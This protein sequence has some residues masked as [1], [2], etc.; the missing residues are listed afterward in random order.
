MK[1]HFRLPLLAAIS[2]LA[3]TA[4]SRGE[5]VFLTNNTPS[6]TLASNEGDA[7]ALEGDGAGTTTALT[8]SADDGGG[9]LNIT[10]TAVTPNPPSL[11]ELGMDAN[12]MGI[13]NE[14]WG[15]NQSWTFKFDRTLSFDGIQLSDAAQ[16][17]DKMSI[18]S[19]AWGSD[20]VTNGNNWSFSTSETAP[21]SGIFIGTITTD[22][23]PGTST[24]YDFTG[25]GLSNIPQDTEI[26]I[27][28]VQGNGAVEMESFTVSLIAES[29]DPS[30]EIAG[31]SPG[32][33]ELTLAGAPD[34]RYE[35]RS[36][37]DL[38]FT[39]GALVEGLVQGNPGTD[40]GVISG[41]NDEF[42]TTDGNGDAVVRVTTLTGP[43]NFVRAQDTGPISLAV[44]DFEADG[45][46]FIPTGDW[47]WGVAASDNGLVDGQVT[48]GNGSDTGKCWATVLGDGG[49]AINGG[50]TPTTDS[51][52]TSPDIDLTGVTG[53]RLEFAAAVDAQTGDTLEVLVRDAGDD[54]LL[55]TITPFA[56]FPTNAA[57][58]ILDF[59]LPATADGNTIYLEFRFQ[60]MNSEFL[61]FYLDDVTITY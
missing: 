27:A 28:W 57:W 37:P 22:I 12:S 41:P 16:I 58:A 33:W 32:V 3:L 29:A 6:K 47:A 40:P 54:S 51:I 34:T 7:A 25:S 11:P 53:A 13:S 52:L 8:L 55:D 46:G 61:G 45:Q 4:A 14:R 21:G 60:G 18:S 20:T 24:I 38:D 44:F 48:G 35:F 5:T 30:L 23:I 56:S 39:P 42:V 15:V 31:V 9:T 49:P 36:S 59:A 50:I 19:T 43:R 10:T 26:T 17:Q 2:S 1:H